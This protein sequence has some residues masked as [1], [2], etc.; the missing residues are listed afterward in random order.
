MDLSISMKTG[1]YWENFNSQWHG[2]KI[3]SLTQIIEDLAKVYVYIESVNLSVQKYSTD[4]PIIMFNGYPRY[5]NVYL[6]DKTT[7]DYLP[8]GISD[9]LQTTEARS[10]RYK[11][12]KFNPNHRLSSKSFNLFR[13]FKAKTVQPD[14][15]INIILDY[16]N[17]LVSDTLIHYLARLVKHPA[18]KWDKAL[19]FYNPH[20]NRELNYLNRFI[21]FLNRRVLGLAYHQ[22]VDTL[23]ELLENW[24]KLTKFKLLITVNQLD[25]FKRSEGDLVQLIDI[26][27]N[28]DFKNSYRYT[29]YMLI[30][31]I[32]EITQIDE[33]ISA[34]KII[35]LSPITGWSNDKLKA[36]DK[37][38]TDIQSDMFYTYLQR[39]PLG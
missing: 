4:M 32:E 30:T 36:F 7:Y 29:R 23:S 24:N 34:T 2:K 26:L 22:S 33:I 38:L 27:T 6:Y 9:I 21:D 35:T 15:S 19:L 5:F 18:E 3:K 20:T 31:D 8:I 28:S 16:I 14:D 17:E 10:L 37:A 12:I 1:Y 13:G 39:Y 11:K 25:L